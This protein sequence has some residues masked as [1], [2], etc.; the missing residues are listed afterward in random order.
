[1]FNY[2]LFFCI[3]F[4]L[5]RYVGSSCSGLNYC[6]GHGMCD[7]TNQKCNC[8]QG[9]GHPDDVTYYRAPDCSAKVCP[10]GKAFGDYPTNEDTAHSLVECSG[11]GKC[12]RVDGTCE[13][14][15]GFRGE[16]CDKTTCINDCSGHGKCV[17]V[18][19]MGLIHE[20]Q[21]V[22]SNIF[23]DKDSHTNK[24]WD[25]D[26]IYGCVCD[27]SWSVGLNKGETQLA[28]WFGP[29][30]SLRHC[31]SGDDPLTSIDES[32]CYNKTQVS[33][34]D[35]QSNL[36]KTGN[37]CQIDCSNRGICDY[38]TGIC[39]CFKGFYGHSCFGV[40]ALAGD[41]NRR[42]QDNTYIVNGASVAGTQDFRSS[43][44]N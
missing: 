22:G 7:F 10:S 28:E 24:A 27:S 38:S 36:G 6:N 20:A 4:Y 17:T 41:G 37:L 1:M 18:S 35:D 42:Y 21:P 3:L 30:C 40:S 44:Y 31:P 26:V 12:N 32:D 16:A 13:C 9:W 19:M 14:F 39:N 15:N 29:D 5:I 11:R 23:Y 2:S 25:G 33:T 43:E 34:V 8:F